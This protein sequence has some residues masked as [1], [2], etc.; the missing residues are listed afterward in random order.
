M[1]YIA[2]HKDSFRKSSA[3]KFHFIGEQLLAYGLLHEKGVNYKCE[4]TAVNA[5]GKPSLI[6][7]PDIFYN[8]SHSEDC[9]V[10]AITDK[11]D[12][13]IDVEMVRDFSMY[14][15]NKVCSKEELDRILSK[16]DPNREFFRYWTL[17]ESYIKF[18]GMGISYPMKS[19]AFKIE[20]DGNVSSNASGCTFRLIEDLEEFVVALCYGSDAEGK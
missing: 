8:I 18:V 13:G 9:T 19:I 5:W 11:F 17:K 4:D 2:L 10:C 1:L 14:A 7:H 12:V 16:D 15:A 20:P 3:F 6:Y